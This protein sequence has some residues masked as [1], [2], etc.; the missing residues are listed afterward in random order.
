MT[1]CSKLNETKK[2]ESNQNDCKHLP[3]PFRQWRGRWKKKTARKVLFLIISPHHCLI[4]TF[5]FFPFCFH[6]NYW[7]ILFQHSQHRESA[8]PWNAHLIRSFVWYEH[9]HTF[10]SFHPLSD[11]VTFLIHFLILVLPFSQVLGKNAQILGICSSFRLKVLLFISPSHSYGWADM[12]LLHI[13]CA[14]S[15]KVESIHRN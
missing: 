2:K 15:E 5:L 7:H 11:C 9:R 10:I 6:I 3:L 1:V 4:R 13:N 12:W 14:Q 8:N